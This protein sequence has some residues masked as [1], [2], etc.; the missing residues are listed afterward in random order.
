MRAITKVGM[1]ERAESPL[2]T[3]WG[4]FTLYAYQF[5]RRCHIALVTPRLEP[6]G[7]PLVRVQ[8]ACLTGTALHAQ[9]CDC[10]QQLHSALR[11]LAEDDI[12]GCALYLDQE[13]RSHG[14][15]EKVQQLALINQGLDTVEA[16]IQ[17]GKGLDLRDWGEAA[18]IL[19]DL[20]GDQPLRLLTN[21]PAK[22]AGL[23]NA[24]VKVAAEIAHQAPVTDANRAYLT[25]K[26]DKLGHKLSL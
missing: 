1:F 9:L 5:P 7:S 23:I 3:E 12:G 11:L 4:R 17:R 26:R 13:G 19:N 2:S 8:S 22:A 21:N 24:G 25:A 14:L 16:A 15:L 6:E 10:R 18:I 20:L